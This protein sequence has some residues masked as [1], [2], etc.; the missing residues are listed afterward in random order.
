MTGERLL[1]SREKQF[2]TASQGKSEDATW[3]MQ[4]GGM[5]AGGI[6]RWCTNLIILIKLNKPHSARM[7]KPKRRYQSDHLG[8]HLGRIYTGKPA[9]TREIGGHFKKSLYMIMYSGNERSFYRK[10]SKWRGANEHPTRSRWREV[11]EEKPMKRSWW[12]K[13]NE[14]AVRKAGEKQ[15]MESE[16]AANDNLKWES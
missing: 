4:V 13:A 9:K 3:R 10:Q 16:R 15:R 12:R 11:D 1:K 7:M 6:Q 5:R 14:E 2:R 8:D